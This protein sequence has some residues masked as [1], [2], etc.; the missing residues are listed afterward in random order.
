M[1]RPEILRMMGDILERQGRAADVLQDSAT[2]RDIKFRSLDFS[3][4][5]LRVETTIG[6]ELNFEAADLRAIQ[7]VGDVCTFIE[8][9]QPDA[10]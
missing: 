5:C 6:K 7:T 3:E 10:S 9:A 4:L 8:K 2:I 1:K